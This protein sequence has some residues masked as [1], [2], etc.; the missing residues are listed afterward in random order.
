MRKASIHVQTFPRDLWT[1]SGLQAAVKKLVP[2]PASE[3]SP[4]P[5]KQYRFDERGLMAGHLI[6]SAEPVL[7][8]N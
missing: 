8:L 2:S 5:K 6:R 7:L 3:P 4:V 1:L